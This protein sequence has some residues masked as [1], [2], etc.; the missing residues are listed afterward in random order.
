[1]YQPDVY[2][3]PYTNHYP[4]QY[5]TSGT[6]IPTPL[7]YFPFQTQQLQVKPE[8]TPPEPPEPAVTPKVASKA[9]E[10]LILLELQH[11]GFDSAE[12]SAANRLELEV[13]T[14]TLPD[15]SDLDLN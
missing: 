13:S 8:P 12:K 9:I 11:A 15:F 1:M 6:T 4:N 3:L 14:C 2:N 5:P 7:S 10:R